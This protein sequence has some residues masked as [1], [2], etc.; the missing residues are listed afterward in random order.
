[1]VALYLYMTGRNFLK[2]I[3]KTQLSENG[4][5]KGN[6]QTYELQN[7]KKYFKFVHILKRER[8]LLSFS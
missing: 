7:F 3:I 5:D 8:L 6:T 1:M 2:L 4:S